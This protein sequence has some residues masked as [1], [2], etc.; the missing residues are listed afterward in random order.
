MRKV[1]IGLTGAVLLLLSGIFAWSVAAVALNGIESVQPGSSYSLVERA[2]CKQADELCKEGT[3]L[4]CSKGD[5]D[6]SCVCRS[7]SPGGEH[8]CPCPKNTCCRT[9][10]GNFKCC[11]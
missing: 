4:V 10:L 11:F 1:A 6:P 9:A 2:D 7:C 8:G 3:M 5:P